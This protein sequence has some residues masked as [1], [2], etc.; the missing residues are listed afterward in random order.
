MDKVICNCVVLMG[1]SGI[2]KGVW[3]CAKLSSD[4]I[5]ISKNKF[6]PIN[7]CFHTLIIDVTINLMF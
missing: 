3:L 1:G 7:C 5:V 2:S 6:D 4:I